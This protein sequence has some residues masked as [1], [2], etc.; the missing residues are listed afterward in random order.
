VKRRQSD[1]MQGSLG[2][3]DH[4]L[5]G[6][7]LFRL[8]VFN[9]G[10]F[11]GRIWSIKPRGHTSLLTGDNGSGKS[12][13]VDALLTLLVPNQK[14][15]YN[16]ASSPGSRRERNELSYVRGAYAKLQTGEDQSPQTQYLRHHDAYS[17]LLAYFRNE[18]KARQ[19]TLAQV[20]WYQDG[21]KKFYVVAP[22]ELDIASAFSQFASV[23]AL[24]E[25]LR[26]HGAEVYDQ[27]DHYSKHFRKLLGLQ[28]DKA[29]DVL[30]QT[31]AIKDIDRLNDFIRQHML[32][33]TDA[34]EKVQHLLDNYDN[35]TRA[36]DALQKAERQLAILEPLMAEARIYHQIEAEIAEWEAYEAAI[37]LYFA[38]QKSH[39]VRATMAQMQTEF[40]QAQSRDQEMTRRL[41]ELRQRDKEL[42]L[43]MNRD[44]VGQHLQSLDQQIHYGQQE[45]DRKRHLAEQYDRLAREYELPSYDDEATFYATR[46]QADLVKPVL[47]LQRQKVDDRMTALRVERDR[48]AEQRRELQHELESLELRQNRIPVRQL[49]QRATILDALDIPESDIPF[50]G[51][52]LRVRES[53]RS[54]E[55]AIER[56]LHNFGL[57]L[58]VPEQ[59]YL[60]FSRHVN[61]TAL[62]GR[63]VFHRITQTEGFT[64]PRHVPEQALSQ[65]VQIKP[66]TLYYNWLQHELHRRFDY[67]CCEDMEAFDRAH[68]AVT[69]E[70]L[71]KSGFTRHEKDDRYD[72][73]DSRYY[74]LGWDNR[75]N[76]LAIT[77]ELETIDT[78]MRQ[79]ET[80]L[81][82]ARELLSATYAK[83]E[84]LGTLLS[85]ND[86]NAI[87]WHREEAKL[88]ALQAQKERLSHSSAHLADLQAEL[89][90]VQTHI[91]DVEAE[92]QTLTKSMGSL[93]H[94][95]RQFEYDLTAYEAE[96]N[97]AGPGVLERYAPRFEAQVDP[98]MTLATAGHQQRLVEAHMRAERDTAER[99]RRACIT[100]LVGAMQR[101]KLTFPEDTTHVDASLQALPEFERHLARIQADD[102]PR[103][104]ERFKTLLNEKVIEHLALL[105]GDLHKYAELIDESVVRLN[106]ALRSIDYTPNTYVH[107]QA[108]PSRD[109]EVRAFKQQLQECLPTADAE[110]VGAE[111]EPQEADYEASFQRIQTLIASFREDTRWT[112]KVTD[113]R[114][115]LDF[116]AS[117]RYRAD[118]SEKHHYSDSAGKSGGQKAK[119][120]YTIL[121]S[122]IAYQYGLHDPATRDEA[123]RF[124]VIDEVFSRSDHDN[125]RYALELFKELG[126]QLL[127]VT[128]MTGLHV[129]EP[130]ISAC[131]FVFNNAEGNQS[132]V[133]NME[134]SRLRGR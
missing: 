30:N 122:A 47:E 72:I 10:T 89:A 46:Q 35:L 116:A 23:R 126:L 62:R 124:A 95:Q 125:S 57:D 88:N 58:L 17:V 74:V 85:F 108:E 48:L 128:P 120:A 14:R 53:E 115:W 32:E 24:K 66:E 11:D 111:T 96:K 56:L 6:F 42:A 15:Y 69:Q 98:G 61:R 97:R 68:R 8:E 25:R 77:Q 127:V 38:D 105:C 113:V 99:R 12:T 27:F 54:W 20:L 37:P 16:Q 50:V 33:K 87:D 91:T 121:A 9:W 70:G 110:A 119:L 114:N 40:A 86:F 93:E 106:V 109:P 63:I 41:S 55:G 79:S 100:T 131:H 129:V 28:S 5:H 73:R 7:R 130:Y 78:K 31:V 2:L 75:A 4:V 19:V 118:D 49:S 94:Q 112:S 22:N 29:L 71:V 134:L 3:Q 76:M 52:L 21:I 107:L 60:R 59:H 18:A 103:Y 36:H 102:L 65:K 39:L 123:F 13:L 67:E 117:E 64:L 133:E 81:A 51:E 92:R 132:Q 82:K 104:R 101:Y 1:V 26:S 44:Q 90:S 34:Q 80:A 43:A 83:A 45:L 84:R